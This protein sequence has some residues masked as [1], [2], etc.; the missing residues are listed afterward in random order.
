MG[1]FSVHRLRIGDWVPCA[2]KS[3]AVDPFSSKIAVGRDN[4]DIE[5]RNRAIPT[6][7]CTFLMQPVFAA[8]L[9]S[10]ILRISGIAKLV[11]PA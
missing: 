8:N 6:V 9:R 5:V 2:I 11:S 4:G 3:I 10:A 1:D 7:L